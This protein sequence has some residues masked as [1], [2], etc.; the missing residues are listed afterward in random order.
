MEKSNGFQ[1]LFLSLLAYGKI[2]DSLKKTN[3]EFP[4]PW[5][6]KRPETLLIDIYLILHIPLLL[7][8]SVVTSN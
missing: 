3:V 5:N 6:P 1:I 4:E 7:N 2:T 8:L